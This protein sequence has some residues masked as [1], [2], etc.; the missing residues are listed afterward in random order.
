MSQ[1]SSIPDA[2][3]AGR[4]PMNHKSQDNRASALTSALDFFDIVPLSVEARSR[5]RKK[6][7]MQKT[8]RDRILNSIQ[9]T[10]LQGNLVLSQSIVPTTNQQKPKSVELLPPRGLDVGMESKSA[11]SP[12][13]QM[14]QT[15]DKT[16]MKENIDEILKNAEVRLAKQES[17]KWPEKRRAIEII[18]GFLKKRGR[19]LN[20]GTALNEILTRI[21]PQLA[22][23]D[24]EDEPADVDFYSPKPIQ[25]MIDISTILHNRGF[26]NVRA[27]EATHPETYTISIGNWRCCDAS[28]MQSK[29]YDNL[30]KASFEIN[31]FKI[32]NP[33][34]MIIDY[35]RT[36]NDPM[37]SYNRL[38]KAFPRLVTL[39]QLYPLPPPDPQSYT[40]EDFSPFRSKYLKILMSEFVIGHQGI[41]IIGETAAAYYIEVGR[42]VLPLK[43]K[44][45]GSSSTSS[46]HH[47]VGK[48]GG[49]GG[50]SNDNNE[51][52]NKNKNNNNK[53]Q[54]DQD[55]PSVFPPPVLEFV[56]T[57]FKQDCRRIA[58]LLK[59]PQN[60][61]LLSY[62]EFRPFFDFT[63]RRG[64]F[65]IDNVCIVRIIDHNLR[66]IPFMD[67]NPRIPSSQA[68]A[69]PSKNKIQMGTFVVVA[70][71]I[72]MQYFQ[73][74]LFN[75]NY[76]GGDK[77][78]SRCK[79]L[80]I[81]L[82]SS[83]NIFLDKR[84]LDIFQPSPFQEFVVQCSGFAELP[85]V[86]KEAIMKWKKKHNKM[87]GHFKFEPAKPTDAF[88]DVQY[89]N[90][91][92]NVI[93]NPRDRW[94]S[95]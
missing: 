86:R 77:L 60:P 13:A 50:L 53:T 28:Y 6:S 44:E 32:T 31:G 55:Q 30:I 68:S 76:P 39:Q 62:K 9:K 73:L 42:S 25:D 91:S 66:C 88:N 14:Y 35:L 11:T 90:T 10:N 58:E 61:S 93:N 24:P 85:I 2:S 54:E 64:E 74:G 67:V 8:S 26:K 95:L 69:D 63:G 36:I 87:S 20:G 59:D 12:P 81:D 48:K 78:T 33:M 29:I 72:M 5:T 16:R 83:R 45:G 21:D 56:T 43:K 40:L 4:K 47:H 17:A 84:D 80:L 37:I 89:C 46:M 22:L 27:I 7:K 1:K 92:G 70:M 38:E 94:F 15:D 23:Y 65:Y 57:D 18:R 19:L 75:K 82:Y 71:F 49:D 3:Q 41:V 79:G 51:N 34:W 52:E